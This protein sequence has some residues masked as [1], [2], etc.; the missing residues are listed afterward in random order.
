M[1]KKFEKLIDF[2]VGICKA[3]QNMK[4]KTVIHLLLILMWYF[5]KVMNKIIGSVGF[6]FAE[7]G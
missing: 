7:E 5:I 4:K 1:R 6:H 2:R 3:I